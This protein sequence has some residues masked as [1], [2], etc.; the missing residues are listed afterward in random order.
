MLSYLQESD[1]SI[2]A[3]CRIKVMEAGD[4]NGDGIDDLLGIDP[5]YGT[6]SYPDR[7]FACAFMR[8]I[9]QSV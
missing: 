1:C 8:K 2:L 9:A 5:N 7:G 4:V 3:G 6:S